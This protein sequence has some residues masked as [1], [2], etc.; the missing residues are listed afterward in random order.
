MYVKFPHDE[1]QDFLEMVEAVQEGAADAAECLATI[2]T[3][4]K[5]TVERTAPLRDATQLADELATIKTVPQD[6]GA[7]CHGAWIVVSGWSG[8]QVHHELTP[9]QFE[10]LKEFLLRQEADDD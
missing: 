1:A 8:G 2:H 4:A 10:D 7:Q 3:I 5:E 6:W 9:A